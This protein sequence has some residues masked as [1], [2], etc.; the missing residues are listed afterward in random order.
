MMIED[1]G[2]YSRLFLFSVAYAIFLPVLL[3]V[4]LLE[5]MKRFCEEGRALIK[6]WQSR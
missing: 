3:W 4:M 1:I 5:F 6:I 2:Y